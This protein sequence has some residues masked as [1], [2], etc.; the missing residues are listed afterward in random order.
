MRT[1][2]VLAVSC[3]LVGA[4]AAAQPTIS[5]LTAST[6]LNFSD[7]GAVVLGSDA[8]GLFIWSSGGGVVPLGE[9]NQGGSPDISNDGTVVSATIERA[10]FDEAGRYDAAWRAL[11]GL[12]SSSGSSISTA[13][14]VS[15]DGGTVVGLA[16]ISAGTA[17]AF[18]WTSATGVVDLGS[19]GGSSRA[20]GVNGDGSVIVGWDADPMTGV[21]RAARWVNGALTVDTPMDVA[22]HYNV[23]ADGTVAVGVIGKN[24]MRWDSARGPQD[25]GQ[26]PGTGIFGSAIAQDVSDDGQIVVGT[27]LYDI[28]PF[29]ARDPI[30]WTPALG[31]TNLETWLVAQGVNLQGLDLR[32]AVA[33]TGDGT[34]I[35]VDARLSLTEPR[36]VLV[37]LEGGCYP[38]CDQSTGVGVLDIFDFICF[39]DAF[40]SAD[41]Y[42]CEC[43]TST[44]AGVCDIFDFICFQDAFVTGCS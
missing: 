41:P 14:G 4:H 22:E 1:A 8:S 35:L 31:L 42:A 9:V 29:A 2:P 43:D 26:L 18:R 5:I 16:W 36:I 3:A 30:L 32:G 39:Q 21:R 24:A 34:K 15:G 6:A 44:G 38:D 12:G 19:S 27:N 28:G 11:G 13:Y 20:N 17:H 33:I 10:G 7:D 40:V 23:S 37:D 25:L